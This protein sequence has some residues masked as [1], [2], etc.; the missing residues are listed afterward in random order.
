MCAVKLEIKAWN[1]FAKKKERNSGNQYEFRRRRRNVVLAVVV[2]VPEIIREKINIMTKL[3]LGH[4]VKR[5][6]RRNV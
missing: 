3:Y 5:H 1:V 2:V 4:H 6:A